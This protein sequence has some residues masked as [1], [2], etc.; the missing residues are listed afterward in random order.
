MYRGKTVSVVFPVFNE[1]ENIRSAIEQFLAHPCVDEVVAVDNDSTDGS[2]VEIAQTKA[3]HVREALRGYGAALQRGM[4]E[5]TGDLIVTTEPDGTFSVSDLD[6]FLAE[7]ERYD[8]VIGSRTHARYILPGANMTFS[9]KCGNWAVARL[10][11]VLF[12]GPSHTDVGDGYKLVRRSAYER[13]RDDLSV[14]GS[15]FSPDF[16]IQSILAGLSIKEIP[17]HYSARI[18]TSKITG[19]R[20]KAVRLGFRMIFFI[21]KTRWKTLW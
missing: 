3:R 10:L 14:E 9:L 8:V 12:L 15:H 7:S 13:I 1:R 6:R 20:M 17:I 5:A 18:G 4:R 19:E 2:D 21:L 11:Q 16:M